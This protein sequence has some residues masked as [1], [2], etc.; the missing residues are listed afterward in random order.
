[1][2][3]KH[4][5]SLTVGQ[6][7]KLEARFAGPLTLRQRNRVQILLRADAGETDADIADDLGITPH[8]AANVRKR[9]AA[10]GLEAALT[11]K[12]RS[13]GPSKLDGKAEAVVV[14]LACS[15]TPEGRTTWTAKL[16]ASKLVEL[17]VVAAVSEDTILRVLKK[18][19]SSRG[20]RRAGACRRG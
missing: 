10:D 14:A 17:H 7:A 15:P 8:T 12:P 6:R 9:F 5:V 13:G 4:F 18:A 1:M 16:L 19:T 20:R 3:K 2:R 11:E